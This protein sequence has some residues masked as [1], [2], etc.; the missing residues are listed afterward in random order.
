MATRSRPQ[1][2]ARSRSRSR[3]VVRLTARLAK[4]SGLVRPR[5]RKP[6]PLD[7]LE[8]AK[9]ADL[10]YVEDSI[11]GIRRVPCGKGFCYRRP[12][13]TL[14]RDVATL[15][16]IGSLV[17]PPAWTKVWICPSE[18][19]HIQATGRDARGRKQYRYHPR[20]REIRDQTKYERMLAFARV[21][22]RI[23][24][25]VDADLGRPGLARDKVLATVVRLLEITLIRVGNEEYAREN[26]SFGLTTLRTRHVDVTGSSIR[27]RF[28]GKSGIEHSVEVHDR[29][30]ARVIA[31]CTDLPGQ[32][33]FQYVD[34]DGTRCT[35]ESAEVNAYLRTISGDEFTA[36]DFR[37]WAGTVLAATALHKLHAVVTT[38]TTEL[39]ATA[40]KKHV[41][42][43]IKEVSTRLGNTASVC[44]KCYVH[45]EVVDAY[46]ERELQLET[47]PP[48]L[49]EAADQPPTL[50]ADEAAVLAFLEGRLSRRRTKL[51]AA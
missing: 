19:G 25:Q 28:R 8:S 49:R 3:T 21:L 46:L 22:P 18:D 1:T 34:D 10:R 12:D 42:Q 6:L 20:F 23:R 40:L 36:K 29:R 32:I 41:V 9:A 26:A 24:A 39:S 43:A 51:E 35:V 14:V 33:L 48:T 30:V 11:P 17:I 7:P 37:T 4:V 27:F 47:A 45:P 44:R 31:R 50:S 2:N 13:G 16:R 5:R 38:E 15:R